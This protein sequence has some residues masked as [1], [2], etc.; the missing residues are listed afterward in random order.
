M[1]QIAIAR[2]GGP[3]ALVLL[4]G[5]DPTAGAGE[6]RIRVRAAGVNFADVL[7][8]MGLYPD[9]PPL[10]F[11]PGYEVSG[12]VDQV[13]PGV[14]RFA[15]GDRVLALTRFA[16]YSDV[17]VVP[18]GHAVSIPQGKDFE[19]AAALPVNYL[20]AFLMLERLACL[21][22]G[23]RV[24]IHG[25]GGGVGLAALQIAKARGARTFGT[26]SAAKHER[27][28]AMGLDHPIDYRTQDFEAVIHELTDGKGVDVALDPNGG[29]S[30]R[31]SYRSLAPL[32]RLV[33]FGLAS[34]SGSGRRR[35]IATAAKALAR[36]PIYHPIKLMNDNKGVIGVN[37]GRLWTEGEK[38]RAMLAEIVRRWGEG[39]LSP[40]IDST[41]PL[42]EAA[43]AH[44]R[45]HERRNF[46]KTLLT[47]GA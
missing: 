35:N 15:T 36:T 34:S 31:K 23:D 43:A 16:G 24:L 45:L 19:A 33:L 25:A 10:P 26:A 20:T 1:R 39:E 28:K 32:G 3:E 7:A 27:L 11:V 47:V 6:I 12:V 21:Q 38:V 29:E 30:A 41:F 22:Q 4:E 5:E 18:E 14:E 44:E 42:E 9:A 8:R 13:G 40:T 17:V 46:G 37:L 2:H